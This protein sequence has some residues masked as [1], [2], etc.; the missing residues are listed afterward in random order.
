MANKCQT[1]QAECETHYHH[2]SKCNI[3]KSRMQRLKVSD[4]DLAESWG[5]IDKT[6]ASEFTKNAQEPSQDRVL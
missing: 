6:D 4:P 2:C 5:I 1:C 3:M